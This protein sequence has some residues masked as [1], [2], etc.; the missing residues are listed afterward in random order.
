MKF[1]LSL[2]LKWFPSSCSV[3]E[4]RQKL[5]PLL[6]KCWNSPNSFQVTFEALQQDNSTLDALY[7]ITEV[8]VGICSFLST[9]E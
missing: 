7:C 2:S 4:F 9:P 8:R 3:L 5:L 1:S 6:E